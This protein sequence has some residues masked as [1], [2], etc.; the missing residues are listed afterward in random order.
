[1]KTLLVCAFVA[2]C[3]LGGTSLRGADD[4][5]AGDKGA[6][7]P[8]V[9]ILAFEERGASVKEFGAKVTDILFAKLVAN[10]ALVLV[11]RDDLK[12]V[13][14]EQ[15]LNLS[16]AVKPAEATKVGQLSGARILVTGS[17]LQ[18]D[19]KLYVIA[20]IIGT[21]T[22]RVLGASVDGKATEEL[23]P[24]VEKLAEKVAE[25]I[26]KQSDKLLPKLVARRDRIAD[27]NEKL[28]KAKR[29]VLLVKITERHFGQA[30]IDP[31]AQTEL[32]LISKGTGFEV[33]DADEALKAKADV[34][35]TGEGF[36][37]FAVRRGSL[38]SVKA[39]V[40]VKAVDR[41]TD[42]V[43]ATDRQTTIVV[44]L[45]EQLAGKTALQQAAAQIAERLLPQ[46][47]KE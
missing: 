34:I 18:V 1:V 9:A 21:E 24:L 46:L 45:T 39:R 17:V 43:L 32:I 41:K 15:E 44:D 16:G 12:K 19:K 10:P 11:D 37:E 3:L 4:K 42:K 6:A 25:T 13:L 23:G 5:A 28:K 27:L 38:I 26:G 30:T 29:P 31:A 2:V 40:E 36:S 47:V 7:V 35:V 20:K 22:G 14:A 8:A 33:L